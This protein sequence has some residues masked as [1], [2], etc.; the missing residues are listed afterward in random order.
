L[1]TAAP[2]TVSAGVS[3]AVLG[4][5][6]LHASWNA[7][8]HRIRDRLVGFVL[9]GIGYM[10]VCAL[11]AP[12]VRGPARAAWPY[13]GGSVA[14]HI[15]YSLFLMRSY[16]LGDFNQMYPL[17]RGTSPWV[18]AIIAA[19]FVGESPTPLHAAG[20]A[21]ISVGLLVLAFAGGRPSRAALPAVAAA[22]V[23]GLAI[24]GYTV[25]DGIGVR[26][27]HSTPGYM[28]WLFLLQGPALPL[29]AIAV[30]GRRL[31]ADCR[32]VAVPGLLSGAI[33]VAAYGIVLWAQTREALATV[34][35]LR[36]VSIVF[37]SLIGAIA[38]HE[39][40]GRWRMA[41]AALAV[42]GIMLLTR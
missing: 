37:G 34:A 4:A 29:L 5:A 8:A 15:A 13:L 12:W 6:A 40:F 32:P 38:F 36:E 35:S 28:A 10:A 7:V 27:A 3:L 17:A 25:L 16:Q 23:T 2:Q 24:A 20:I 14:L 22:V 18:V 42:A 1:L 39:R 31:L 30:R 41:G 26:S 9:I 19:V 11:I 33:S 21:V